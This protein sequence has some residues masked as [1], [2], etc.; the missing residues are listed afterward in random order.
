MSGFLH[1]G[2][3]LT[4]DIGVK[5]TTGLSLQRGDIVQIALL[6]SDS[7]DGYNVVIPSIAN[8]TIGQHAPYGVVQAPVGLE[9]P[10][11]EEMIV[12]IM[13][14]TD[15]SAQVDTATAYTRDTISTPN[16]AGGAGVRCTLDASVAVGATNGAAGLQ[17]FVRAHAVILETKTTAGNG[18]REWVNCFWNG[19]P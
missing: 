19:L 14:V 2:S 18:T 5:N 1:G 13:G 8:D 6:N 12:R 16:T 17:Q 4:L 9:I 15:I 10:N 11:T 7:A 3:A